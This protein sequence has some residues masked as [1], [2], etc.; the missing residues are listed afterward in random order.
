[1][2]ILPVKV[3][4]RGS[5]K[6]IAIYAFLD[7][8]SSSTYCTEA[9]MRQLDINGLKTKIPLTTLDKKDSLIDSFLVHDLEVTDLDENYIV[10]PPILYTREEIPVSKDD[11]PSQEDV[12]RWP[13]FDGVYLPTVNCQ[14]CTRSPGS[15]RSEE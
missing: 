10:K 9:L 2:A 11:I 4:R 13:H 15:T 6:A 5:E 12:D 14:R 8:G 7:N 3:R 1:M